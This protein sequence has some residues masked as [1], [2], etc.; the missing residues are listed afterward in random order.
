MN[1]TSIL[2]ERR[3]RIELSRS[4]VLKLISDGEIHQDVVTGMDVQSITIRARLSKVGVMQARYELQ[5]IEG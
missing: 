4:E 2:Q 3:H 5:Q 1:I